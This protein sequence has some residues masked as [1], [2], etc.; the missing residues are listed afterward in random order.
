MIDGLISGKLYGT[1]SSKTGQSGWTF[2][3]AKVR[4]A[5]GDSESLF[6][7][8]IAFDDKVKA[9]LLAHDDGDSVGRRFCGTGRDAYADG[10]DRPQR[11]S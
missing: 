2:V 7:N 4:A 1:P 5:T 10:M 3:T 11:R 9:A 6:V 8:V